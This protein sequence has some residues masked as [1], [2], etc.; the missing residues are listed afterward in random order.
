M[1]FLTKYRI[2]PRMFATYYLYQLDTVVSWYM[3]LQTPSMEQS[4][5][6]SAV[7]AG[8]AAYFKFYVETGNKNDTTDRTNS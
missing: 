3:A 6:A 4:G 5:F 2:F 1:D 8:A 7:V